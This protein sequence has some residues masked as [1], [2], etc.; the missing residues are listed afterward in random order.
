MNYPGCWDDA[1]IAEQHGFKSAGF[2]DSPVISG[3]PFVCMA[4]AANAT[5][6]TKLGTLINIPSM[7]SATA[8]ASALTSLNQIAPGRIFFGTGTGYTGRLTAGLPPM[9]ASR[10]RDYMCE[11]KDV[12]AG[13]E[14]M[15]KHEDHVTAIR[16]A[17][18]DQIR[19][20]LDHPVPA[21]MAADGPKALKAVGA[22]ADG[23]IATMQPCSAM[24]NAPE[25]FERNFAA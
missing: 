20:N 8:T 16:M 13:R 3:D 11:I 5:S 4:L 18:A 6:T 2:V 10:V 23:W 9:A 21:Y 1:A 19:N 25:V 14:V 24:E 15:H 17:D 7:R 12:M 22:K